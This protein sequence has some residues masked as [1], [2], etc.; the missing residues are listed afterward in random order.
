MKVNQLIKLLETLPE[1]RDITMFFEGCEYGIYQVEL[2]DTRCLDMKDGVRI[3]ESARIT[4][5]H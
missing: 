1:D 5:Q 4:V 3:S 2:R